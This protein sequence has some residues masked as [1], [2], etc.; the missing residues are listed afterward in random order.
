LLINYLQNNAAY[1]TA[2]ENNIKA[3]ESGNTSNLR[4]V[5]GVI[6]IPVVVNVLYR[7]TAENV[8]ST[9]SISN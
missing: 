3:I 1:E 8:S 4:L 5:N 9:N 2:V 7:T 6:E